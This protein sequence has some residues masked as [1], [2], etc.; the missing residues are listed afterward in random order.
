M[1]K[2]HFIYVEYHDTVCMNESRLGM[3]FSG[4]VHVVEDIAIERRDKLLAK[5]LQTSANETGEIIATH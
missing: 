3:C 4:L 1:T 2:S 5:H